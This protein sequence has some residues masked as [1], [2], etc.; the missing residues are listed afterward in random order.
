MTNEP[1]LDYRTLLVAGQVID[2]VAGEMKMDEVSADYRNGYRDAGRIMSA[3]GMLLG[4][5][6]SM[7]E[8]KELALKKLTA[9]QLKDEVDLKRLLGDG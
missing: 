9:Q 6:F 2:E 3:Y 4:F 1:T 7:E 8:L 5:G